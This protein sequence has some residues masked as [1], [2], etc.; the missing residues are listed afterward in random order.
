MNEDLKAIYSVIVYW[1]GFMKDKYPKGMNDED[2]SEWIDKTEKQIKEIEKDDMG[3][4]WLYRKIGLTCC[5]FILKKQ[6]ER[7]GKKDV[8]KPK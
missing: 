2:V 6:A 8:W 7:Q 3:L 4:A 1:W 5:D